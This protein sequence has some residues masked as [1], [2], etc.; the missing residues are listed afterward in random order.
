MSNQ[1]KD[2]MFEFYE[3]G[4][5]FFVELC[6]HETLDDAIEVLNSYGILPEEYEYITTV[7]NEMA[8]ILGY[9]TY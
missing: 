9:D 8:D 5:R 2:F 7:S 4:E 1:Y 6:E 3:S